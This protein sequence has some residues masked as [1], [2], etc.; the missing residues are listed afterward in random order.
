MS[1]E[2]ES[3]SLLE[4]RKIPTGSSASISLELQELMPFT[5][6][7]DY[8]VLDVAVRYCRLTNGYETSAIK[9]PELDF[10]RWLV[11]TLYERKRLNDE[12]GWSF[13]IR[14]LRENNDIYVNVSN[15]YY[16]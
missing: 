7:V 12:K 10:G 5:S 16:K 11:N 4:P 6:K 1:V 3:A 14:R 8:K 9:T 15:A 13:L 2:E